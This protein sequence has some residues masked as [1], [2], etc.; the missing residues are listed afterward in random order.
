M[1]SLQY[2]NGHSYGNKRTTLSKNR[3][4]WVYVIKSSKNGTNT[5]FRGAFM[6]SSFQN[7]ILQL[8]PIGEEVVWCKY[9]QR[10]NS[11][12]DTAVSLI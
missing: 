9:S 11:H 12:Q 8:A 6:H 2:P 7:W 3:K 10:S 5:Y 4:S 1:N